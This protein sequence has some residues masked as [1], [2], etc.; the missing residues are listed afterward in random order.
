MRTVTIVTIMEEYISIPIFSS[1][2]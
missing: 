1:W 2:T